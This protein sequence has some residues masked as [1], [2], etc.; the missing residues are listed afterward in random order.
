MEIIGTIATP[1]QDDDGEIDMA[2]MQ[3]LG[4]DKQYKRCAV[5][6]KNAND[7]YPIYLFGDGTLMLHFGHTDGCVLLGCHEVSRLYTFFEQTHVKE[8]M[9]GILRA[10]L[11]AAGHGKLMD[12]LLAM[13][14]EMQ[15][16]VLWA[17]GRAEKPAFLDA[18]A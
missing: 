17:F 4:L 6:H 9:T 5:D 18:A 11:I 2:E 1:Q 13:T 15:Q 10:D 3:R 14:D 7:D 16:A 8:L 12:D